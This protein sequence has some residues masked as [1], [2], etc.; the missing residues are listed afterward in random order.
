MKTPA[1]VAL[2]NR[3]IPDYRIDYI[4]KL[5]DKFNK[6]GIEMV[7]F[8]GRQEGDPLKMQAAVFR[9][10]KCLQLP[11]NIGGM[12]ERIVFMPFLFYSLRRWKPSIIITED[13]SA[14]PNCITVMMYSL[15]F[16]VPYLIHGLG[17]IPNRKSSWLKSLLYYPI[18]VFRENCSGFICYSEQAKKYYS[19]TYK[20]EC[21]VAYNSVYKKHSLSEKKEI[22]KLIKTRYSNNEKCKI[23]YLG[24]LSPQKKV[25][26]IL[27]AVAKLK[28]KYNISAVIIGSG[29]IKSDLENIAE[30]LNI[31]DRVA[32]TG[33]IY[34]KE[35]KS[36]ILNNCQLGVLPGLGG[37][38]IQEMLWHALPVITSSADGTEIDMVKNASSGIYIKNMTLNALVKSIDS[39]IK[40]TRVQK[41]EMSIN[42]LNIVIQ[43]YNINNMINILVSFTE[44]KAGVR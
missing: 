14:M 25:D 42:G 34:S 7:S 4:L 1:R 11:I 22:V 5:F 29:K 12:S 15:I 38:A 41:K 33:E 30:N 10:I 17:K 39:F 18:K 44:R 16:R 8:Y 13:I 9:K 6:D 19:E 23:V 32:F 28:R 31:T 36:K 21:C 43:K 40:M 20:N 2:V 3:M 26:L 27:K 35:D 37:L 24:R